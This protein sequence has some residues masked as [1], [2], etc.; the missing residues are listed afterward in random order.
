M[1]VTEWNRQNG[2][3]PSIKTLCESFSHLTRGTA[4]QV[5][6]AMRYKRPQEAMDIID[7]ILGTHG[8]EYISQG[9]NAKSPAIT[10]CNTGDT[11]GT[12]ILYVNGRYRV[13]CWG[14]IVE[15]GNYE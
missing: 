15:R 10:Y 7:E 5:R 1:D 9:R 4:I 12:T 2:S 14:D 6:N 13:G 3:Y 8:V 11:Y